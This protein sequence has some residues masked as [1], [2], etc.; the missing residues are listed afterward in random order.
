MTARKGCIRI[1][2]DTNVS[3]VL[4]LRNGTK[5]QIKFRRGR[6]IGV[7]GLEGTGVCWT[8]DGRALFAPRDPQFDVVRI[9]R[10]KSPTPRQDKDAVFLM[11]IVDETWEGH[12]RRLRTIAKRL[13]NGRA[14]DMG[15]VK[16]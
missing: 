16:P 1:P 15:L 5:R 10:K 2:C 7:F 14:V 13:N 11:K 8:S 3:D 9:E 12:K 6:V 4:F